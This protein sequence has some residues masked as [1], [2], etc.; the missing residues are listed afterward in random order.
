VALLAAIGVLAG[1][2]VAYEI[3]LTRLFSILL[4]HHFAYMIISVALLGIGAS[5]TFLAFARGFLATHFTMAFVG[6]AI[7]FAVAAV[8]GFALAQRVPFNP[9]EVIWDPGQQIYLAQIYGL[10]ALPFFAV[11]AAIG[12]TFISFEGRIAA[13]YR[14]DLIGAASGALL[15]IALL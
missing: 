13:I 11:G 9:L 5:G 7:L 10:L 4:W 14:A 1:A 6:C 3:L 12:L 15:V 8:G 2:S